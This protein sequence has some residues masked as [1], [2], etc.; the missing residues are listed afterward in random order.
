M[1]SKFQMTK[2]ELSSLEKNM[3]D[4]EFISLLK[5]LAKNHPHPQKE[6]VFCRKTFFQNLLIL[7]QKTKEK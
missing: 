3:E 6:K 5:D 4:P 2:D 1:T 7:C